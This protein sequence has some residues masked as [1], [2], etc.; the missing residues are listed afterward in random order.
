MAV[1]AA[2]QMA[3]KLGDPAVGVLH[4]LPREVHLASVTRL[5]RE[6]PEREWVQAVLDQ[7]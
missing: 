6:P 2:C 7:L 5:E 3:P 1:I 4:G